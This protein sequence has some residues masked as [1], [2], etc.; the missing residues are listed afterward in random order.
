MG[1]EQWAGSRVRS[2][3]RKIK[4]GSVGGGGSDGQQKTC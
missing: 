4:D 2:M 1:L 3:Q